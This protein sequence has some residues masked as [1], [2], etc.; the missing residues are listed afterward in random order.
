[1]SQLG[2]A[3]AFS[4][5]L[6]NPSLSPFLKGIA[7]VP[8]LIVAGA[9]KLMATLRDRNVIRD[10]SLEDVLVDL[11]A[12]PLSMD[13]AI[14]CFQWWLTLAANRS[15]DSRLLDR[16]KEAAMISIKD[17]SGE[18]RIMPL[19]GFQTFRNVKTLPLDCP[20]PHHTLPFE[21]TRSF[22]ANDLSNVFKF[23]ELSLVEF[24]KLVVSPRLIGKDAKADTNMLVSPH[25]VEKVSLA[26][27]VYPQRVPT[28]LPPACRFSTRWRADGQILLPHGAT[29]SSWRLSCI[30]SCRHDRARSLQARPIYRA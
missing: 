12:H 28:L 19:A 10:I 13:E 4:V 21:L 3:P 26:Q 16:L 29:R 11:A 20:A 15:Y 25:F 8:D 9:P 22:N 7:T 30:H 14:K 5:R 6:P 27:F 17:D 2:P 23:E 1:M 24:A 18:E